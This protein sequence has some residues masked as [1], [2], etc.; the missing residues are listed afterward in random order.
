VPYVALITGASSGIGEATARRLARESDTQLILVARRQDR[1]AM[2]ADELGNDR[3]LVCPADLTD[4][5][6]PGAIAALIEQRFGALNLLVNNAGARWSMD[7]T[8]GGWANIEQHMRVNFE[9]PVR[10]VEALLPL[11]RRT[12]AATGVVAGRAGESESVSGAQPGQPATFAGRPLKAPVAIVNV[13]STAARIARLGTG[14]YSASKNALAA[15]N[16]SLY[17]EER[18][19]GV[20]VGNVLPGFI[21]SEGF[22]QAELRAGVLTRYLVSEPVVVAEAILEAGPG[23][24]PERYVPRYYWVGALLRLVAPDLVRHWASSDVV[25]TNTNSA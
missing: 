15:W 23:G 16:D 24:R 4:P 8:D 13:T 2:L 25:T 9:A 10:L 14:G 20:H 21:S 18:V 1:L 22:P 12:A 7:F 6:A 19:H 5:D 11:M 3:V 17:L